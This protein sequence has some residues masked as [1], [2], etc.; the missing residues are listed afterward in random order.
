MKIHY[1]N[2]H[3]QTKQVTACG[4]QTIE[5][6]YITSSVGDVTCKNCLKKI[7]KSK[8]VRNNL[9]NIIKQW[10]CAGGWRRFI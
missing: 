9:F 7:E 10:W 2:H 8:P 6:E 3:F 1:W 4:I 5:D